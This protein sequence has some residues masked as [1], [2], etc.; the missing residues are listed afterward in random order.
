MLTTADAYSPQVAIDVQSA[1]PYQC[2]D[3]QSPASAAAA[4]ARHWVNRGAAEQPNE[5]TPPHVGH[6]AVSLPQKAARQLDR[7]L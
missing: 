5:R 3:I 2:R 1:R 7:Q 4:R 6:G